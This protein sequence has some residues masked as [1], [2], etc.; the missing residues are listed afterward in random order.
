MLTWSLECLDGANR[1]MATTVQLQTYD[2][3]K[4]KMEEG[5]QV[6]D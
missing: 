6:P 2:L 3:L 5:R 1:A 4:A